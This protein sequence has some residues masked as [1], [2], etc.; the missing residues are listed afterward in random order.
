MV[1]LQKSFIETEYGRYKYALNKIQTSDK[2]M[3]EG[4]GGRNKFY[5]SVLCCM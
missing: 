3:F 5:T 4:L 1:T 2:H